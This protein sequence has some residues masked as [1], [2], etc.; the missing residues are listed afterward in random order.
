MESPAE[1][2]VKEPTPGSPDRA[3][4]GFIVA[5]SSVVLSLAVSAWACRALPEA[6]WPAF[7]RRPLKQLQKFRPH[8]VLLGNSMVE[9]R[10]DERTLNRMLAPRRALRLAVGGSMTAL[11]YE[12]LKNYVVPSGLPLRR[13]LVFFRNEEL[14]RPRDSTTGAN[15]TTI[16]YAATAD[17]PVLSAK[18]VPTWR[19]PSERLKYYLWRDV[20]AGRLRELSEAPVE[21]LAIRLSLAWGPPG[22]AHRRKNQVNS[23][24]SGPDWARDGNEP[25]D[26]TDLDLRPMEKVASESFLADMLQLVREHHIP[27][28]FV[29][30]R[31]RAR[32]RGVPQPAKL[33][34]YTRRLRRYIT[35]H[36]A[37]FVDMSDEDW[38]SIDLYGNGDHI[39]ARHQAEYTKAIVQHLPDLFR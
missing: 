17:D 24:F 16:E 29:R 36:G 5:L 25:P 19:T 21:R 8:Y 35:E 39:A 15:L 37:D 34:R 7:D 27:C 26:P 28:V 13:L 30:I 1:P 6:P 18:L 38:E 4:L 22:D 23:V 33:A 2:A 9:S 10:F 20:P 14:T 12:Q 32:A 11:W 3:W 31:T